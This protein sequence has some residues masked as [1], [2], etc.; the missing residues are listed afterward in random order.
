[1]IAAA[2]LALTFPALSV[3]TNDALASAPREVGLFMQRSVQCERWANEVVV[4]DARGRQIAR[5]QQV[6][7][8][9]RVE[10]DGRYLRHKYANNPR[11]MKLLK[12]QP[13]F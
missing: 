3:Q 1:M 12:A 13:D 10:A 11:L 8:C 4:D 7:K 5:S 6:L 9:D 2:V